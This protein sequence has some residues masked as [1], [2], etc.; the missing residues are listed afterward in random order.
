MTATLS[1]AADGT[2][3]VPT[4]VMGYQSSRESQNIWTSMID[5]TEVLTVLPPKLRAGTLDL[6]YPSESAAWTAYA[7]LSHASTLWYRL[8]ETVVTPVSMYFHRDGA[9]DVE[10][11]SETL[12]QWVLHVGYKEL[13]P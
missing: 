10:L 8:V 1:R 11:D 7:Y 5:G 9:M 3:S 2:T 13:V 12:T 6:Y 4:F